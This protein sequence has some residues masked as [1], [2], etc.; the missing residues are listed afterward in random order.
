MEMP[1]E[2]LPN[3]EALIRMITQIEA[4]RRVFEV[5]QLL[6]W[7]TEKDGV[8]LTYLQS[9]LTPLPIAYVVEQILPVIEDRRL[10]WGYT[11]YINE[12][13]RVIYHVVSQAPQLLASIDYIVAP[14]ATATMTVEV[15]REVA[16]K[17]AERV[18]QLI[19]EKMPP[20]TL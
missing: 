7:G 15:M 9:H 6:G 5:A 17:A 20:I 12:Y 13:E 4:R 11:R 3:E 18:A 19:Q 14:G 10:H 1:L 8:D 2:M 16:L